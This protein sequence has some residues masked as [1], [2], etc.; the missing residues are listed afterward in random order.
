MSTAGQHVAIVGG[1]VVGGMS[2]YYLARTGFDVT[3]VDRSQFGH[4]CSFGNCGY[5]CPSHVLPLQAPGAI[6]KS[7]R[8]MLRRNSPFTIKPRLSPRF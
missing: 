6:G 5:V 3:I 7:L 8:L 2:A 1:G 4:A